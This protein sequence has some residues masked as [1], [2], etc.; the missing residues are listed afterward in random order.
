MEQPTGPICQCCAMPLTEEKL[1]GIESEG[2]KN[3]DYCHLCYQNGAFTQPE[4]TMKDMRDFVIDYIVKEGH[5]S[6]EE[7]RTTMESVFPTLK[8]WRAS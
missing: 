4:A 3:E 1:F 7:A 8:R 2:G 6:P 5:M